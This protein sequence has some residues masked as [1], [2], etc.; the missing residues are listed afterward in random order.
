MDIDSIL[1]RTRRLNLAARDGDEMFHLVH[2]HDV[3]FKLRGGLVHLPS[4][5]P[6]FDF[7]YVINVTPLSA[8]DLRRAIC[9]IPLQRAF[10]TDYFKI[11]RGRLLVVIEMD[12]SQRTI[13]KPQTDLRRVFHVH[14]QVAEFSGESPNGFDFPDQPV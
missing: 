2:E 4:L 11:M 3:A 5:F 10:R 8:I 13:L 1:Q 6:P 12:A 14:F 7:A 9:E